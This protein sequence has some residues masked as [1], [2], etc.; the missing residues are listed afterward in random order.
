MAEMFDKWEKESMLCSCSVESRFEL[1]ALLEEALVELDCGQEDFLSKAIMYLWHEYNVS[2][3]FACDQWFGV[4]SIE[5]LEDKRGQPDMSSNM[6]IQCDEAEIGLAWT[7]LY[8]TKHGTKQNQA[9]V[10]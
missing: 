7:V 9:L 3:S 6:F 10:H 2:T 4:S 1:A 8:W 5:M